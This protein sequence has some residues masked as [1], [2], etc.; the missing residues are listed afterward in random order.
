MAYYLCGHTGS[1]NHSG[2]ATVRGVC[3]LLQCQPEL[4]TSSVEEDWHYGL[5]ALAGLHR[6][7]PG[8]PERSMRPGDVCLGLDAARHC[9][10]VPGAKRV[11]LGVAATRPSLQSPRVRQLRRWDV[12]AARDR[13]TADAL[14]QVG[15]GR[16]TVQLPDPA[17]LCMPRQ[18]PLPPEFVAGNTV[19]IHFSSDASRMETS[20]GVVFACYR[21][22][23]GT[24]LSQTALH[25]ALIPCRVQ[26]GRSDL[27]ALEALYVP[28]RR[29]ERVCLLPDGDCCA[30]R[31]DVARCSCFVGVGR[32][33]LAAYACGVPAL[34]VACA[35]ED[36]GVAED[37]LGSSRGYVLPVRLMQRQEDLSQ[38]FRYLLL[39]EDWARGHLEAALPG[40]RA[41]ARQ[42]REVI[43]AG[44]K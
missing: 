12:L 19:G 16:R 25:V 22:L 44:Q 40:Y 38:S 33:V 15:L 27:P 2:E 35:P 32:S 37:L 6:D 34:C 18:R 30:L 7:T 21:H 3:T 17:F 42:A 14:C 26:P 9:K 8:E 29:S 31:G 36:G 28:Y 1:G 39:R 41:W 20:E 4:Y 13:R 24:I 23:I 11:L 43:G 5:G 10:A